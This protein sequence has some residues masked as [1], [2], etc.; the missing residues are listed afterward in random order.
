MFG[1]VLLD[2]RVST[3]STLLEANGMMES[4]IGLY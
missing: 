3:G 1:I 4:Q 2:G